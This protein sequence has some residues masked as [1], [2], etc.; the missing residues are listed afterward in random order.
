MAFQSIFN[1]LS[2]SFTKLAEYILVFFINYFTARH[3]MPHIPLEILDTIIKYVEVTKDNRLSL[4]SPVSKYWQTAV[5]RV[6]FNSLDLSNSDLNNFHEVFQGEKCSRRYHLRRIYLRC[7]LPNYTRPES[8][9]HLTKKFDPEADSTIWSDFLQ[10]VFLI[11][12]DINHTIQENSQNWKL[13]A[14]SLLFREISRRKRGR[15]IPYLSHIGT[16]CST[17]SKREIE[18]GRAQPGTIKLYNSQ[19]LPSLSFVSS[20]TGHC[21]GGSKY[22][23]PNWISRL[24]DKL[25]Q[26]REVSLI[27]EDAYDWGSNWRKQYQ[28]GKVIFFFLQMLH[29]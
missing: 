20:I 7:M 23:H 12:E 1:L 10:R 19:F 29:L 17:H 15:G 3:T 18:A 21:Y 11:L 28:S 8:C 25:P 13:P 5:E 14:I 6:T 26:L 2:C 24:A 22:L 4:Y 9:C 27:I 16:S